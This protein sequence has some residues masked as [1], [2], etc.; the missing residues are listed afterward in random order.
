MV[1]SNDRRNQL[2]LREGEQRRGYRVG[3]YRSVRDSRHPDRSPG[4]EMVT[5]F[6][7]C[8]LQICGGHHI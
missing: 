1:R 7:C 5:R 8:D 3:K 4:H 2:T 6:M